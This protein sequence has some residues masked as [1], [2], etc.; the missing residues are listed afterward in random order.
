MKSG[1]NS[2]R[3]MVIQLDYRNFF[4]VISEQERIVIINF[5]RKT[6]PHCEKLHHELEALSEVEGQEVIF[7]VVEIDNEAGLSDRYDIV[8]VPTILFFRRGEIKERLVGFY[9]ALVIEA[10]IIKIN[11]G[12][13]W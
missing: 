12:T 1:N 8:S 7:G 6:C 13:K 2:G 5:V 11:T 9:S 3:V 4:D 10:N